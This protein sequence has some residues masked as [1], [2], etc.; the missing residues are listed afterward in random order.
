MVLYT[1]HTSK[2]APAVLLVY[3]LCAVLYV[4]EFVRDSHWCCC[5]F[6]TGTGTGG[7]VSLLSWPLS[8]F[9][10]AV[11]RTWW[12]KVAITQPSITIRLE[13][14]P[15]PSIHPFAGL[16]NRWCQ[17]AR[18]S[19]LFIFF[20]S[21][22]TRASSSYILGGGWILNLFVPQPTNQPTPPALNKTYMCV[23]C[24][25]IL[26]LSLSS[27]LLTSL[28]SIF[29]GFPIQPSLSS[30]SLGGKEKLRDCPYALL[31]LDPEQQLGR[32]MYGKE[33]KKLKDSGPFCSVT[34][35]TLLTNHRER[36]KT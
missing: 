18:S 15:P 11:P 29:R 35:K 14:P 12:S 1:A 20:L 36:W 26:S 8:H 28:H 6:V 31:L 24:I 17:P 34:V 9:L 5:C 2:R 32:Y 16:F 22:L 21:W 13:F 23:Y 7:F 25:Y 3:R 33:E 19:S 10:S 30:D 4:W 27:V